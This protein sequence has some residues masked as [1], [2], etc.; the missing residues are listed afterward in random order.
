M[1]REVKETPNAKKEARS[2]AELKEEQMIRN[3]KNLLSTINFFQT[4]NHSLNI[5]VNFHSL[6][7]KDNLTKMYGSVLGVLSKESQKMEIVLN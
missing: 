6:L 5:V 1:P 2:N 3:R 7:R 4:Y